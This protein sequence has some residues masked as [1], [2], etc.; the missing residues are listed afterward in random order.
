MSR[1]KVILVEDEKWIRLGLKS[2]IHWEELNLS[3]VL[4][5]ADGESALKLI[6]E[7]SPEIIISDIKMPNM[8]GLQLV[9][10]LRGMG[11]QAKVILITAFGEF[12]YA[13]S[14]I[15]NGV[16]DYI[17]KPIQEEKVTQALKKCIGELDA[18]R[19][20]ASRRREIS[21]YAPIVQEHYFS[22]LM[23]AAT[24]QEAAQS[25]AALNRTGVEFTGKTA[26]LV[27][28]RYVPGNGNTEKM[29]SLLDSTLAQTCNCFFLKNHTYELCAIILLDAGIPDAFP[30][31]CSRVAA[32]PQSGGLR[33]GVGIGE[34]ESMEQL[35]RS[36]GSAKADFGRR[37]FSLCGADS[38]EAPSQSDQG[39]FPAVS[40]NR[41]F[42][43]L[44]ARNREA[45]EALIR[46]KLEEVRAYAAKTDAER[47]RQQLTAGTDNLISQCTAS[48]ILHLPPQLAE[49]C[50]MLK[51]AP[52]LS[53]YRQALLDILEQYFGETYTDSDSVGFLVN[54]VVQYIHAHYT[55]NL[56][57]NQVAKQFYVNPSYFS[58]LFSEQLNTTFTKYL[59]SYRIQKAKELLEDT[60][61]RVYDVASMVGI[62]DY[63][64]FVK[65]FK[66]SEGVT[67]SEYRNR[68]LTRTL[69][70]KK[71]E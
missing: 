22:E 50:G 15:R 33:F 37:F 3:P 71:P 56:S 20:L 39:E 11:S 6:L 36:Y 46:E 24:G 13:Q 53:D 62:E 30:A 34:P 14:A 10:R 57:M 29:L 31:L 65:V 35:S 69:S 8:T 21:D 59:S 67:P 45:L 16:S 61:L 1:Y 26:A 17:L 7:E 40:G 2:T 38:A 52:T 27:T 25:L 49:R 41:V 48:G 32:L 63:R 42:N 19:E 12:S 70:G 28:F 44:A 5:A 47:T 51:Y 43:L 58:H 55:E 68:I 64:Y 9:E 4:E 23:H 18:E 60:R 54:H 66:K